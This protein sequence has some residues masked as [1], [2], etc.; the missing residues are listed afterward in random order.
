LDVPV[1]VVSS[2]VPPEWVSE[3]SPFTFVERHFGWP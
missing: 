1:F 2:S 3:G